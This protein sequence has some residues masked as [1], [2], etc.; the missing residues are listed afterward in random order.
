MKSMHYSSYSCLIRL[1]ATV[2]LHLPS[3]NFEDLLTRKG[4]NIY[5]N[6]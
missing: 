6:S 2:Y 4:S 5:I 1:K 3:S